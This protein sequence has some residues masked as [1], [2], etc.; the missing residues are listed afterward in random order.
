MI[1]SVLNQK[2]G[3]GKSTITVNLA[4]GLALS[5]K[6]VLVVD[7]DPQ[8]HSSIIFAPEEDKEKTV[9]A[10]FLN[11]KFDARKI[12]RSANIDGLNLDIIPSNINLAVTSE[13]VIGRPHRE[14]ILYYHLNRLK[15]LY[16]FILIDSPPNLGL[17]TM[18]A[19]YAADHFMIPTNYGKYSLD[20]ISD[21]F[22]TL[23]EVKE[24][25]GFSFKILRSMKDSRASRTNVAIEEALQEF[26]QQG[27]LYKTIIRRVEAINQA[28]MVD[29][30]IYQHEPASAGAEDF[31]SLVKEVVENGK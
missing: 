12:A 22:D 19:I 23:G 16:D 3:V 25:K 20:G 6:K 17:L 14:K 9:G 13:A 4:Y 18:N 28:Q 15:S 8:A 21:L 2:G 11:R 31:N 24:G 26:E 5:G 27:T 10:L 30:T 1:I 7:L 29:Q